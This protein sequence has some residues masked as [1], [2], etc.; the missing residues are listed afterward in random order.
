M[1]LDDIP[2]TVMRRFEVV[3]LPQ[4]T[5]TY[6]RSVAELSKSRLAASK[7]CSKSQRGCQAPLIGG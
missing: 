2:L 1:N 6:G 4:A 3:P 7:L 5:S